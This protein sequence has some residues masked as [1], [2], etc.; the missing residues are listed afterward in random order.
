M[1]CVHSEGNL[2]PPSS[3][4]PSPH[5]PSY[6][7]YS[8]QAS[9]ATNSGFYWGGVGAGV[10]MEWGGGEETVKCV[11]TG[12]PVLALIDT[13]NKHTCEESY[14]GVTKAGYIFKHHLK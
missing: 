1:V 7:S 10:G 13:H 5:T 8:M 6:S 4:I 14:M 3:V 11:N 2:L 9:F 12:V